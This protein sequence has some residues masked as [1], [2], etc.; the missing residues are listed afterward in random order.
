MKLNKKGISPV[1]AVLLLIVITVAATV[2]L[3]VWLSGFMTSQTTSTQSTSLSER[4][5]FEAVTLK[6]D[7]TVD[8]YIRNIG[9]VDVKIVTVY[10]LGANGTTVVAYYNNIDKVIPVGQLY[11]LQV[12]S[13]EWSP[14]SPPIKAGYVYTIKVVTSTGTEF[15]VK[16]KAVSG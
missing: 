11:H 5:K 3:Y 2:L 13:S 10:I 7:G 9:D 15:S 1:I 16:V 6:S 4:L 12:S 8:A 14:S